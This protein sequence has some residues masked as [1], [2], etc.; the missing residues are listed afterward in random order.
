MWNLL[1]EQ[2]QISHVYKEYK[3]G[4][5]HIQYLYHKLQTKVK[6]LDTPTL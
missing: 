1:F 2:F 5:I 4:I 3:I 6:F